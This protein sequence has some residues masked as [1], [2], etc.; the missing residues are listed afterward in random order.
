MRTKPA[1]SK[2]ST[3]KQVC[4]LIPGHLAAKLARKHGVDEQARTFSPWSHAACSKHSVS[5][6][7]D[8]LA[9]NGRR[10]V[11]ADARPPQDNPP[12]L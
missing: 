2:L 7:Q 12:I 3:L 4:E 10:L 6:Q 8:P 5:R 1:R 11:L 9:P